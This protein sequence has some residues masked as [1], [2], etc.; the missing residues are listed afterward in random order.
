MFSPRHAANDRVI[1][2]GRVGRVRAIQVVWVTIAL[3]N[4]GTMVVTVYPVET[5]LWLGPLSVPSVLAD[6]GGK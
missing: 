4:T 3:P 6:P 5:W 1:P 2:S